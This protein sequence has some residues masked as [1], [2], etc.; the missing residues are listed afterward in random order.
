MD[1]MDKR[2][3]RHLKENSRQTASRISQNIHLSVS[4]VIER[5]RKLE[6]TGIIQKYTVILDERQLGNALTAFVVLRL[7][8]FKYHEPFEREVLAYEDICECHAIAGDM[9]YLMKIVTN[10]TSSLE[11]IHQDLRRMPGVSGIKTLYV[12]STIK[13]EY[14]V[15]PS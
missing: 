1:R 7:S 11:L 5:I 10:S 9:D 14:S 13:N 12:L 4:A 2:I 8:H 3:L 15:L 6:R